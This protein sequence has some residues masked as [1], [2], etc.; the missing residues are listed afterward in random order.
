L[1]ADVSA[2][3][4]LRSPLGGT[5]IVFGALAI[6]G[7]VFR[8]AYAPE[9]ADRRLALSVA[10]ALTLVVGCV[11]VLALALGWWGGAYFETPMLIQAA[12]LLSVTLP[13][14]LLWLA[15]YRWLADHNHQPLQIC[16]AISLLVVLAVAAA[17]RLNLGR[18]AI[19]VGPDLAVVWQAAIGMLLL[20]LP[21]LL[22]EALRRGLE[23]VTLP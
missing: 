1:V 16:F 2:L 15:S 5:L 13:S 19:L 14:C 20:W 9:G 18:G 22:Y 8:W 21:I 17:H 7:G 23:R 3:E 12:I 10:G 4:V 11:Y 6:F